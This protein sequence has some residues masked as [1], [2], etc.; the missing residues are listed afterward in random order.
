M[1][2]FEGF[3]DGSV[4]TNQLPGVTFAGAQVLSAGL[5]LNEFEFP[6]ASGINAAVDLG[7]SIRIDFAV[8][9]ITFS[10]YFTYFFPLTLTAFDA[11]NNPLGSDVSLFASNADLSGDAGSTPNELLLIAAANIAYVT[12]T[13]GDPAGNSFAMDDVQVTA[14]PE[15]TTF[16][17]LVAGITSCLLIR[18]RRTASS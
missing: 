4:L 18:Y 14:I 13:G 11:A 7:G 16:S 5:S 12:I 1:L 3:A 2:T 15:P 10:G 8:P 9:A 6:P 17:I